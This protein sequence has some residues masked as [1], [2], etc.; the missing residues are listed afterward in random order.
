[1]NVINRVGVKLC[2]KLIW[3]EK[4]VESLGI[5]VFIVG[6]KIG[7]VIKLGKRLILIMKIDK[8]IGGK[9]S[10]N[11]VLCGFFG[12]KYGFIFLVNVLKKIIIL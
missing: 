8:I 7:F 10:L 12:S 1:M 3:I 5:I 9:S 11:G 4:F 6:F 2:Y